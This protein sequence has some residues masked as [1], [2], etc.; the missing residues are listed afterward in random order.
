[1]DQDFLREVVWPRMGRTAKQH[2]AFHCK[3]FEGSVPFPTRRI[4]KPL[5]QF[6]G[7]PFEVSPTSN[8]TRPFK[9]IAVKPHG[10]QRVQAAEL[11]AKRG[12]SKFPKLWPYG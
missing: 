1:M 2:D 4:D 9:L 5:L 7:Q 8:D 11:S 3:Q 10:K 12:C 6:V